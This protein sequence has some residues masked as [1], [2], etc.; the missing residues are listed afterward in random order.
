[1]AAACH[2]AAGDCFY[3]PYK[4][5]TFPL[6]YLAVIALFAI[7]ALLIRLIVWLMDRGRVQR[8]RTIL[9]LVA[10][11]FIPAIASLLLLFAR[12]L[13]IEHP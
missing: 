4:G 11:S 7:T 3:T 8:L 2:G 12:H 10:L 6:I 1:M 13:V 5:E 9:W